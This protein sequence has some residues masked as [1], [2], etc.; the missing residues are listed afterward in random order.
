ML[1]SQQ[2]IQP[3]KNVFINWYRY[4]RIEEI[5][6]FDLDKYFGDI[7]HPGPD[8]MDVLDSSLSWIISISPEGYIKVVRIS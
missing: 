6:F 1:L 3:E 2:S 4:D 8:E 7:W 5:G